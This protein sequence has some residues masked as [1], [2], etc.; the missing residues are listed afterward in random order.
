[1]SKMSF[2]EGRDRDWRFEVDP[3][4]PLRVLL[5]GSRSCYEVL[6]WGDDWCVVRGE[7]SEHEELRITEPSGPSGQCLLRVPAA[8]V[9]EVLDGHEAQQWFEC[10]GVGV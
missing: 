1:M 3:M 4:D 8:L 5:A 2:A 9:R 6:Q 7:H 10:P